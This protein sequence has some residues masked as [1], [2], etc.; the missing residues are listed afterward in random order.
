[1]SKPIPPDAFAEWMRDRPSPEPVLRAV[2]L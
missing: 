2:G 1:M